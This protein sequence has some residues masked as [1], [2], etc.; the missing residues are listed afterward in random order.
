MRNYGTNF[1]K[2]LSKKEYDIIVRPHPHSLIY[3]KKFI[4]NCKRE[5]IKCKNLVWD[6]SDSPSKSMNKSSILISDTSSIRFDFLFV[7]EK[8]VIT[9]DINR[10]E[11]KGYEREY[12][13]TNWTDTVSYDISPVITK[14]NIN[15]LETK[16]KS[17]TNTFNNSKFLNYR[18]KTVYNFGK[19]ANSI[20]EFFI[21]K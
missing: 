5:L 1:I 21:N 8:P 9:L 6:D 19:G 14:K 20:T 4:N 15:E 13:D 2:D 17:L 10:D 3:E 16:I 18:N 12:L 11:M 7:H